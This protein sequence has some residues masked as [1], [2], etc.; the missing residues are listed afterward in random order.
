M[1]CYLGYLFVGLV[2]SFYVFWVDD[3]IVRYDSVYC[4]VICYFV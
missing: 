1:L 3:C 2:F 4:S